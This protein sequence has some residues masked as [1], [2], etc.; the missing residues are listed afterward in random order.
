MLTMRKTKVWRKVDQYN[1]YIYIKSI[2]YTQ[3]CKAIEGMCAYY[4]HIWYA[5][6]LY[7]SPFRLVYSIGKPQSGRDVPIPPPSYPQ[8]LHGHSYGG[9]EDMGP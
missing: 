9:G 3:L 7:R 5:A 6:Y 2:K 1:E 8:A 4:L